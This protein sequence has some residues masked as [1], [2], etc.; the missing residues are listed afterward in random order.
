[1]KKNLLLSALI[2]KQFIPVALSVLLVFSLSK[3]FFG[4]VEMLEGGNME[5]PS[6]WNVSHLDSEEEAQYEFNSNNSCAFCEGGTLNVWADGTA[7]SNILFWQP[8]TLKANTVYKVSGAF[9]DLTGGVINHFWCEILIGAVEPVDEEDYGNYQVLSFNT[10][11]ECTGQNVDGTFQDDGTCRDM[12]DR[13]FLPDSLGEEGTM[14]FGINVGMWFDTE[15]PVEYPYD[16][17]VD[18]ISL[19]DSAATPPSEIEQISVN[20]DGLLKNYPNPFNETTTITYSV[21]ERGDISLVVYNSVGIEVA[22]LVN[23]TKE[24]GTYKVRFDASDLKSNLYFC[25]LM[26]NDIVITRKMILLK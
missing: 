23:E 7:S 12:S 21:P 19:L 8:V 17:V 24:S 20:T 11:T 3:N 18:E 26:M 15:N 22:T 16:I 1:M 6:A 2:K 5:D 10:W 9:I 4:Q 14:Y 13:F 25:R